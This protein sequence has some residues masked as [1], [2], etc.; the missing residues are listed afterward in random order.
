MDN[1]INFS[2]LGTALVGA[3]PFG[4]MSALLFVLYYRTDQRNAE[5]TAKLIDL[6]TNTAS[7]LRDLTAA[8]NAG[9]IHSKVNQ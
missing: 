9:I 6:S 4:I 7:S 3:G 1:I 5:M 2:A 8:I